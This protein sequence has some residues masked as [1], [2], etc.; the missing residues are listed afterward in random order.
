MTEQLNLNPLHDLTQVI[1][2]T[3]R[4]DLDP[5]IALAQLRRKPSPRGKDKEGDIEWLVCLGGGGTD[6]GDWWSTALSSDQARELVDVRG[7][8]ASE[9]GGS[10]VEL[11]LGF[12]IIQ[13]KGSA[14]RGDTLIERIRVA[15]KDGDLGVKGFEVGKRGPLEVRPLRA[16]PSY[17]T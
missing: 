10:T 8:P 13:V 2:L 15:W 11:I 6:A 1:H 16:P 7:L 12:G 14:L 5:L 17:L 3:D 4:P 9:C